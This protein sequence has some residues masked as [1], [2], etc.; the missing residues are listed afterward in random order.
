MDQPPEEREFGPQISRNRRLILG[1][2]MIVV[3]IGLVLLAVFAGTPS[4]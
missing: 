4:G 2:G 3:L 1:A